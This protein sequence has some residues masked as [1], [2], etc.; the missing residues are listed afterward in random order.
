MVDNIFSKVT[1]NIIRLNANFSISEKYT[2]FYS[3]I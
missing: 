2:I 3:E 1:G